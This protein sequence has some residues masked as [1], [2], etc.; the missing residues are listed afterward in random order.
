MIGRDSPKE[1]NS[2]KNDLVK[3]SNKITDRTT[4]KEI[5]ISTCEREIFFIRKLLKLVI[6]FKK[7]H[8]IKVFAG[9]ANVPC[10]QAGL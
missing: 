7:I 5:N 9:K 4:T 8:K 1:S 10:R 3:R 6:A 2:E